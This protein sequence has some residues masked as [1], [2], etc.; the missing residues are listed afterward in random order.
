MSAIGIVFIGH[1][2]RCEKG[3]REFHEMAQKVEHRLMTRC[4]ED[5][6]RIVCERA[7]LELACPALPYA[8]QK[9]LD[10]AAQ[11][12]LAVPFFLFD[13]GHTKTDLA[14]LM[15][16]LQR[17]RPAVTGRLLPAA[18]VDRRF[19]DVVAERLMRQELH[20]KRV[21]LLGRGNQDE[22]AQRQ[23]LQI[24]REI[25]ERLGAPVET[26]F[27]AG[28][29]RNWLVALNDL[30][31]IDESPIFVQPYLWFHG[32]LTDQL[33]RKLEEWQANHRSHKVFFGE[34]LGTDDR[35]AESVHD[36]VYAMINRVS[37]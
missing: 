25:S 12:I 17:E 34:P 14:A 4:A 16:A 35:L 32:R 30:A 15:T 19:I 26:G 23:F 6:L 18:G 36:R 1:G 21:L 13:A 8:W 37:P 7:F 31:R 29:G 2:T 20:H 11:R 27:L 10:R 22:V 28:T 33:P 5:R 3:V 24:A 9:C